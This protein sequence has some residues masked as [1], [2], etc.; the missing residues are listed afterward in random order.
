MYAFGLTVAIL[1]V[2]PSTIWCDSDQSSWCDVEAG[3]PEYPQAP[4]ECCTT[5]YHCNITIEPKS[6][7]FGVTNNGDWR[8]QSCICNYHFGNCLL[9]TLPRP[10]AFK[11]SFAARRRSCLEPRNCPNGVQCETQ[12]N[13]VN[14]GDWLS[15]QN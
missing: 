13:V 1:C 2:L 9:N 8:L 15:A 4:A 12:Y 6:S 10:D 11:S 7:K 3:N 14:F 5:S